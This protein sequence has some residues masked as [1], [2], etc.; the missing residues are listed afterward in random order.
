M[1]TNICVEITARHAGQRDYRVHVPADACAEFEQARHDHALT[2][3]GFTFGWV[4]SV[5]EVLAAW[6]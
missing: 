6:A 4:T 1:T 5:D 3:I 2:T